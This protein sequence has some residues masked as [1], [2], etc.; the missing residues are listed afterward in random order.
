MAGFISHRYNPAPTDLFFAWHNRMRIAIDAR[1]DAALD[2]SVASRWR[3]AG[4]G[5][6][7][8][9]PGSQ[10]FDFCVLA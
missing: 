5:M 6:R 4:Q 9:M 10:V 7:L 3:C 2:Q 8:T 1:S